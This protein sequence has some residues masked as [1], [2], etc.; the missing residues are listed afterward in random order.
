MTQS[1]T[2]SR[3]PARDSKGNLIYNRFK[4]DYAQRTEKNGLFVYPIIA[5]VDFADVKEGDLGGFVQGSHNLDGGLSSSA[6]VYPGAVV[7]GG[8]RVEDHA[9]VYGGAVVIGNS[10]LAGWSRAGGDVEL[11]NCHLRDNAKVEGLSGAIKLVDCVVKGNTLVN[12]D[13]PEEVEKQV[14]TGRGSTFLDSTIEGSFRITDSLL[15]TA[16]VSGQGIKPLFVSESILDGSRVQGE[17]DIDSSQIEGRMTIGGNI[18]LFDSLFLAENRVGF[19]GWATFS[20]CQGDFKNEFN[21][22]F[23]SESSRPVYISREMVDHILGM[24]ANGNYFPNN[25]VSS[26]DPTFGLA[27][28][29]AAVEP[30]VSTS[31]GISHTPADPPTL[32]DMVET[33]EAEW[34]EG[35]GF[36]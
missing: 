11:I 25:T 2:T 34:G 18:S 21:H 10:V 23:G 17:V 29:K 5:L 8:A 9:V 13:R 3:S 30:G 27:S 22:S 19:F 20:R 15:K 12:N 14:S 4:V 7:S 24:I 28:K 36:L 33:E 16:E 1:N 31:P 6:W 35:L 32:R 26:S